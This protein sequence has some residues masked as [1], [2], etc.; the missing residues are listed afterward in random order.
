MSTLFADR[1]RWSPILAVFLPALVLDGLLVG[2]VLYGLH[3]MRPERTGK[4]LRPV[5]LVILQPKEEPEEEPPE[6]PEP[7]YHGQIVEIAPDEEEK[8]VEADYLADQDHKVDEESRTKNFK[9]NPEIL[10]NTYS[11]EEQL[12]TEDLVDLNIT[13]QSTGAQVGN[14][15]FDPDRD[16]TL[17]SL[18]SPWAVTNK[19]G[20]QAPMMASHSDAA[21]AGAPQNDLLDEKI[22][23][24]VA[25]NA[26]EYLYADYMK[27]IR[28]LVNFYWNQ[29]LDNLPQSVVF[30]KTRYRTNVNVILDGDGALEFIEV[31]ES[32][33]SGP[34]DEAVLSAFKLAGPFPNP[35]EGLISKDGRVYLPDFGFDVSLGVARS[36]NE[37]IDPRANVRFPGLMKSPR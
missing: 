29:N 20:V 9:I 17:A 11:R 12:K 32:S 5:R 8:P 30:A 24:V 31:V 10:S 18:P 23:D 14:D 36:R 4:E 16:G 28:R 22:S 2:G 26:N 19:E 7:E 6:E 34:L 25:L 15:R 13:E 27:R 1:R 37:G 35:P 33:G 3:A 21:R